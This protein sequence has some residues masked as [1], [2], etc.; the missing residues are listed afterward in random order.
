MS[1]QILKRQMSKT[2][3]ASL[4]FSH[5]VYLGLGFQH[6]RSELVISV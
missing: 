3:S 4:A 1:P 2:P 5:S 6:V